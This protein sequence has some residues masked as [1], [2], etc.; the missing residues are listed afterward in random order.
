MKPAFGRY[1]PVVIDCETSGCDPN[2]HGM[3][4]LAYSFFEFDAQGKLIPGES[5]TFH[6]L[7]FEGA[8]FDP[9][10]MKIHNIDPYYPLR[11]A[12]SE[13]VVLKKLFEIINQKAKKAGYHRSILVGHN[14]WFDLAFLN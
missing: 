4:E 12:E 6:I 2:H 10:S 11:F 14:A 1:Y 13:Q 3:L 9:E 7:P 8:L 5:E